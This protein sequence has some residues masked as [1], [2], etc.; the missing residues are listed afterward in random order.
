MQFCMWKCRRAILSTSRLN[1]PGAAADALT[2]SVLEMCCMC[3]CHRQH[4]A[5]CCACEISDM[6]QR[7][8]HEGTCRCMHVPVSR[9]SQRVVAGIGFKP[10]ALLCLMHTKPA[11]CNHQPKHESQSPVLFRVLVLQ[12]HWSCGSCSALLLTQWLTCD[13]T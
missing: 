2:K 11:Q 13:S 5:L 4:C 7:A 9:R 8:C 6:Q 1:H 10:S 3:A 12:A